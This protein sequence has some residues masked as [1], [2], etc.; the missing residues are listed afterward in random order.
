M[1]QL[2][3]YLNSLPPDEQME[4]ARRCETSVGY[5]RKAVSIRQR[6]GEALCI[7]LELESGGVVRLEDLRPDVNWAYLETRRSLFHGTP[8]TQE[9]SHA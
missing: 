6:I 8:H 1:E 3:A 9:A 5:L 7:R 2:L 4:F